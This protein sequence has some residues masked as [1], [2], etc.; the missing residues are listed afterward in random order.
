M[1]NIPDQRCW[2]RSFII[3][4]LSFVHSFYSCH[5][6]S[7]AFVR[8]RT[9]ESSFCVQSCY[10]NPESS[11]IRGI[12]KLSPNDLKM[13]PKLDPSERSKSSRNPLNSLLCRAPGITKGYPI[14]GPLLDPLLVP[15]LSP[16]S[17]SLRKSLVNL[18]FDE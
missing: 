4:L 11:E 5:S 18:V 16:A 9:L 13:I 7:K 6:F 14:L 12:P 17:I 15:P 2:T 10:E 1:R 8:N 3:R